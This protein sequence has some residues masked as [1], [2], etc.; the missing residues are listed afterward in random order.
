MPGWTDKNC[1]LDV[2]AP[3]ISSGRECQTASTK[4]IGCPC[5]H[6]QVDLPSLPSDKKGHILIDKECKEDRE[7]KVHRECKKGKEGIEVCT[8]IISVGS[9]MDGDVAIIAFI[10]TTT[11][12]LK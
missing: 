9:Q 5:K 10:Y 8:V 6:R 12:S 1:H 3:V 2:L 7:F 4:H 11:V